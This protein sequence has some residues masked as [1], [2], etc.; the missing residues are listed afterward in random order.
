MNNSEI[1]KL[2]DLS[3]K[4]L[5]E[6]P[7]NWIFDDQLWYVTAYHKYNHININI[8]NDVLVFSVN[9]SGVQIPF[10]LQFKLRSAYWKARKFVEGNSKQ[11]TIEKLISKLEGSKND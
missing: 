3:V 5:L 8:K 7:N 9:I 1:K 6:Y 2:V 4:D 10:L 11:K